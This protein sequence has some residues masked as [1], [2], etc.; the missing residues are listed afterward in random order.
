[1]THRLMKELEDLERN[2][3][4][5]ISVSLHDGN[6]HLWDVVIDGPPATPYEGGKFRFQVA[7]PAK[8]PHDRPDVICQTKIYHPHVSERC[9]MM[10]LQLLAH[11]APMAKIRRLLADIYDVV[12]HPSGQANAEAA[13]V[14]ME[15][16]D[17][18]RAT[19]Q[20]WT[21]LYAK[22]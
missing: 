9:G 1:M 10:D 19:A 7:I 16:P 22:G 18:F 11:W 3:I 14:L 12:V 6:I 17:Q 8:Y 4:P 5:G 20:E 21:R 15:K 13:L 2:P